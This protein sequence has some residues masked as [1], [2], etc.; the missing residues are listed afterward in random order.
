MEMKKK[1]KKIE[2]KVLSLVL[3]TNILMKFM[4]MAN[5]FY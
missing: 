1:K 2:I 5:Y 3:S 4:V